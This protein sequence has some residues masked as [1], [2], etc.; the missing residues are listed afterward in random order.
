[1]AGRSYVGMQLGMPRGGKLVRKG[2]LA[3]ALL[4]AGLGGAAADPIAIFGLPLG[5]KISPTPKV[6]KFSEVASPTATCFI[7]K[8][9]KHDNGLYGTLNLPDAQKPNWAMYGQ[10][11]VSI[12]LDG[13]LESLNYSTAE[14]LAPMSE[15]IG[16]IGSR[17]GAPT[18][19][20]LS[21]TQ[22][23]WA[24]W[25]LPSV[26]ISVRQWGNRCCDVS[27]F[28]PKAAARAAEE[29]RRRKALD[30]ARPLSP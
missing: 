11:K 14:N 26:H 22:L 9:F 25:E 2:A 1:M 5:G 23:P 13:E 28:T 21:G 29:V 15:I 30:S 17:F 6:C 8:P 24:A 7:D 19:Q 18:S 3:T 4:I 12:N 10:L 20:E 16:S 27:F